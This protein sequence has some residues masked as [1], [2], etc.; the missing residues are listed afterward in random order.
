MSTNNL[1]EEQDPI[2]DVNVLFFNDPELTQARRQ[3]NHSIELV[4]VGTDVA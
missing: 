3:L 2:I 4:E 1:G